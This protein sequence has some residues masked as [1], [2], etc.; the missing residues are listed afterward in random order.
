MRWPLLRAEF[1]KK[2]RTR[3][4]TATTT[5]CTINRTV[6]EQTVNKMNQKNRRQRSRSR[7]RTRFRRE[8]CSAFLPFVSA[9]GEI[10]D[11]S[12]W[13][14]IPS[15]FVYTWT[16][17]RFQCWAREDE[18]KERAKQQVGSTVHHAEC[19]QRGAADKFNLGQRERCGRLYNSQSLP[20]M[21]VSQQVGR[22]LLQ[23]REKSRLTADV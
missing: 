10:F 6:N 7:S 19:S 14:V 16:Y 17:C 13:R 23:E 22:I 20:G 15:N 4:T 8:F 11:G 9:K 21:T 18:Q 1:R 5:T 2:T 3:K 12:L